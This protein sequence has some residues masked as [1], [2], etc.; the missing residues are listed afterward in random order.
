MEPF[1]SPSPDRWT[2]L[3]E[4]FENTINERGEIVIPT[5]VGILIAHD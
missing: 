2:V 5:D 4:Y 1:I 3:R